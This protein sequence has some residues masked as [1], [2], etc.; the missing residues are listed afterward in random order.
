QA[1]LDELNKLVT[2]TN[3]S[4]AHRERVF[5]EQRLRNV[6]ADLEQAELDLSHFSSKATDGAEAG[7]SSGE[8]GQLYPPLR[9]MPGLA[10]P[11]ADL[12]RRVRVEEAMFEL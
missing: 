5:I 9:Q 1:Y 6:Q 4:A 11:Y 12:Y 10:V 7:S 8:N 2:R 3:T